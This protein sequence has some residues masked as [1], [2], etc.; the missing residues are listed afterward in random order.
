MPQDFYVRTAVDGDSGAVVHVGGEVD[1]YTSP[2][3]RT[4]LNDLVRDGT[5]RLALDLSEVSFLDSSA[6]AVL[7]GT[8]KSCRAHGGSLTIAAATS[9]T[10]RLLEI[11]GLN[12]ALEPE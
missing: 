10:L 3:L 12:R 11:T 4:A 9:E 7:L 5:T 1:T 8:A 2:K 6:L